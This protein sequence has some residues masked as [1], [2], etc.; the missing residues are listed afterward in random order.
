MTNDSIKIPTEKSK[1]IKK[2]SFT[3]SYDT[4]GVYLNKQTF[5]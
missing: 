2:N 5:K 3:L 4:K 1:S